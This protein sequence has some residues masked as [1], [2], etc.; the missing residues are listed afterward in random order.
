MMMITENMGVNTILITPRPYNM[1]QYSLV[2][3]CLHK[4]M[5]IQDKCHMATMAM[6]IMAMAIIRADINPVI[7]AATLIGEVGAGVMAA[8]DDMMMIK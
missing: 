3:I 8:I 1:Y 5:G 6:G 4:V 7:K 2:I